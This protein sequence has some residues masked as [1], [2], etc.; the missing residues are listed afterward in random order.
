MK[1]KIQRLSDFGLSIKFS[2]LGFVRPNGFKDLGK[3]PYKWVSRDLYQTSVCW[4][5]EYRLRT[6]IN[7]E[8]GV[9]FR[10]CT[11]CEAIYRIELEE[12]K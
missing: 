6:G 10:Y 2:F 4:V 9:A 1:S 8:T 5:C 12:R 11:R 3:V 7:E